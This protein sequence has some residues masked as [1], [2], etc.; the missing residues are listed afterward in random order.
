MSSYHKVL[1]GE[2]GGHEWGASDCQAQSSS[3]NYLRPVFSPQPCLK[4]GAS[5][6]PA[7]FGQQAPFINEYLVL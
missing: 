1:V 6:L 3:H 5:H 7:C 2:E 4:E